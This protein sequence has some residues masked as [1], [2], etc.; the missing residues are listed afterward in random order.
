MRLSRRSTSARR[1]A[2]SKVPPKLFEGGGRTFEASFEI[3]RVEG[4]GHGT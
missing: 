3:L 2:R 1:V 4:L